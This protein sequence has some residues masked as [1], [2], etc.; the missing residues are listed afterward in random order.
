MMMIRSE[1]KVRLILCSLRYACLICFRPLCLAA[2]VYRDIDCFRE[3][4]VELSATNSLNNKHLTLRLAYNFQGKNE[5]KFYLNTQLVPR[6]K[7]T[8][9]G[10][11]VQTNRLVLYRE[12]TAVRSEVCAEQINTC[13][14]SVEFP[15]TK[16][17]GI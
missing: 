13:E 2:V 11:Y 9:S 3:N 14:Q 5:P 8:S 7:H 6:C 15:N 4:A 1:L 16:V 17:G 10:L 12:I